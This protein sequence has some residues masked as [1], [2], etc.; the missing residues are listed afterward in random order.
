M[1]MLDWKGGVKNAALALG[2]RE[3]TACVQCGFCDEKVFLCNENCKDSKARDSE[4][5]EPAAAFN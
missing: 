1:M 2:A 5:N 4:A 3:D